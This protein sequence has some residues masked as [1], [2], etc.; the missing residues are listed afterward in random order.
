MT[1]YGL[2]GTNAQ[3]AVREL[4]RPENFGRQY[5]PKETERLSTQAEELLIV[6][7]LT[8][9]LQLCTSVP[10]AADL[11]DLPQM[12][13]EEVRMRQLNFVLNNLLIR[14]PG[15]MQF[16]VKKFKSLT[17]MTDSNNAVGTATHTQ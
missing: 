1:S 11:E 5:Y 14:T 6:N 3:T 16:A 10:D 8:G 4:H 2:I 17:G 9:Q 12:P 15:V 7:P 13:S